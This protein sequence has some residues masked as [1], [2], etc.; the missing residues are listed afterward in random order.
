MTID[1]KIATRS[2]DSRWITPV[3]TASA[4]IF[5]ADRI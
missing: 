4:S 3:Q 5:D 1:G 2:G